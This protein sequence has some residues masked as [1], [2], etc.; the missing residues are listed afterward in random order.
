MQLLVPCQE[1]CYRLTVLLD[2]LGV[3]APLFVEGEKRLNPLAAKVIDCGNGDVPFTD[4]S[5]ALFLTE[6]PAALR[7]ILSTYKFTNGQTLSFANLLNQPPLPL[8]TD[9]VREASRNFCRD[10]AELYG[11]MWRNE[12]NVSELAA[13][14]VAVEHFQA[15][16]EMMDEDCAAAMSA[17]GTPALQRA[18]IGAAHRDETARILRE[19]GTEVWITEP[20]HVPDTFLANQFESPQYLWAKKY[21]ADQAKK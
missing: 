18:A 5:V 2:R 19:G 12:L 9:R 8:E 14:I 17:A 1:E 7:N 15:L 20:M 6:H 11:K 10:D 13:W 16:K 4:P 21:M 3:D